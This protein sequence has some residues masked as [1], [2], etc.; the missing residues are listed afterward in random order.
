M[1]M[2]DDEVM[3]LALRKEREQLHQ[4]IM[5]LD[6][7]IK[8]VKTGEYLVKP[9]LSIADIK[10]ATTNEPVTF[11]KNAD[12][13]I[14]VL[15]VFDLIR[16]ASK[17]KDIQTEYNKLNGNSYPLRDT[18]R[19]LHKLGLLMMIKE[20]AAN[21]AILWVKKEWVENGQLMDEYKP[22]GFDLLHRSENLLYQ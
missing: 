15:K 20:R 2:K 18:L 13:K 1:A 14:Q 21:R 10:Q 17:F 4:K 22:E 6:R 19:G 11:P 8:K 3:L 7:I 9:S 16:E 12:I 5:Q